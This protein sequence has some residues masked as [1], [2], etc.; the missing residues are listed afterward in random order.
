[1][2]QHRRR[3]CL[4]TFVAALGLATPLAGWPAAHAAVTPEHRSAAP[5]APTGLG[6]RLPGG[7]TTALR[8]ALGH[9]PAPQTPGQPHAATSWAQQGEL[10]PVNPSQGDS[11]GF[12]VAV[13]GTT[14][15]VGAPG[16][17]GNAGVVFVFTYNGS[18]WSESAEL[19]GSDTAPGDRFG[20][21]VAFSNSTL[22]VGAPY[23]NQGTGAI[24]VFTESNN[25]W[26]QQARL[27]GSN[28]A[29]GDLLG[30][31]VGISSDSASTT[32][33]A[34]AP[35]HGLGAG[36]AYLFT[37]AG[38]AWSQQAVVSGLDTS[39]GDHFGESVSIA[40]GKYGATA[41]VGAPQRN[42]G[43]GVAY[44]FTRQGSIWTQQTELS[45]SDTVAADSFGTSVSLYIGI[46]ATTA[47]VGAP[48][49]SGNTGA[50]YVFTRSG[51]TWAQ[52]AKLAALDATPGD[53]FGL[54]VA[55]LGSKAVLGAPR[56]NNLTGAAYVFASSH[57][58]WTQQAELSGSDAAQGDTFGASVGINGISSAT[59]V[60]GAPA[61][62]QSIGAAYAFSS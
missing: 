54:S 57:K 31:S 19:T 44:V 26:S 59:I 8:R 14:A 62:N 38:S 39:V 61:K 35:Q 1:M 47:M 60:A 16:K 29:P 6:S 18:S 7:L 25:A 30:S 20:S 45:G 33:I 41:L 34:G 28:T 13:G 52:Q 22:V 3:R 36:A 49:K 5:T 37:A 56:H 50:G 12:A 4:V 15:I 9:D 23:R 40:G 46:L 27:T 11:S 10:V 58:L 32:A 53:E 42:T 24:Y 17:N 51:S 2:R 48:G 21:A 55:T 43:A